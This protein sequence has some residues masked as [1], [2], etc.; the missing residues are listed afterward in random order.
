MPGL[1]GHAS[2]IIAVHVGLLIKLFHMIWRVT[3]GDN[4]RTVNR[5]FLS[6][7][8]EVRNISIMYWFA[9]G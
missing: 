5:D 2:I 8:V 6:R 7:E 4:C 3:L 9:N 1:S